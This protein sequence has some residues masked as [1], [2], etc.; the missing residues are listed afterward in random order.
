MDGYVKPWLKGRDF[1]A[2]STKPLKHNLT[3]TDRPHGH[4]QERCVRLF[5]CLFVWQRGFVCARKRDGWGKRRQ[6]TP[7]PWTVC[8]WWRFK[9]R[10]LGRTR[11]CGPH[12]CSHNLR[13]LSCQQQIKT[14]GHMSGLV[15]RKALGLLLDKLWS[16][17]TEAT[18]EWA[19]V[20][21]SRYNVGFMPHV[22][23][24]WKFS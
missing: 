22:W 6:E 18:A 8:V 24:G 9:R 19:G 17:K 21:L 15:H 5:V 13:P 12:V 3:A 4:M 7:W 1:S 16:N 23:T 2:F 14:S 10:K 20:Q 11:M